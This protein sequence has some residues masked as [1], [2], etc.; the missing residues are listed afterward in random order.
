MSLW[1]DTLGAEVRYHL[2]GPWRT[3]ALEA[4]SGDDHVIMI[5]GI[6]G[7]IEGWSRNVAQLAEQGLNVHA[8]DAIGHGYT[9]KPTDRPYTAPLFAEHVI[10]FM[11]SL[12]IQRAHLVGQSLGGWIALYTAKIHAERVGKLVH[13]TGA[14]ILLDDEA[15]AQESK[16]V[17]DT[18]SAVTKK[19]LDAPTLESV[20]KR[21]EWLMYDPATVTDELVETRYRIYTLPDSVAAMPRL[22]EEAPGEANRPY[23]LT[24]SDLRSIQNET[25]ILWSDHNPTTPP[26]VGRRASEIMPNAAFDMITDSGHWPMFEQPEQ[27]NRIVGAFLTGGR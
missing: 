14:G 16:Q 23:M 26:E 15:R 7:H 9:D 27:F 8:I 11:D 20:R 12:G 19:A 10:A 22:V 1:T 2:A 21:L 6:T 25:L 5:G 13:V 18:V 24:E 17:G 4:G 3:R